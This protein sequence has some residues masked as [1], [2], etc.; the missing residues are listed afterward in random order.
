MDATTRQ[1]R[2]G[3]QGIS[4]RTEEMA[5][6][7]TRAGLSLTDL[8]DRAGISLGHMSNVAHGRRRI[9]PRGAARVATVLN[10]DIPDVFHT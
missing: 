8:A 7:R 5:N 9:S 2:K 3:P 4:A 1:A 10:V 6:L